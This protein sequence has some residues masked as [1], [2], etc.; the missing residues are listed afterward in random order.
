MLAVNRSEGVAPDVN[1]KKMR[2]MDM[3]PPKTLKK[4]KRKWALRLP[5]SSKPGEEKS[6]FR[7]HNFF[8]E[9]TYP[10]VTDY[11]NFVQNKTSLF[12]SHPKRKIMSTA[13]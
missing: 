5:P 6:V 10:V 13:V 7:N 3:C 4:R 12:P 8:K 11:P 9:K 1:L 2:F